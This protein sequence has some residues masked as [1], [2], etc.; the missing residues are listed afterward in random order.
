MA[1]PVTISNLAISNCGSSDFIES[2]D[3]GVDDG[4]EARQCA[5]WYDQA[6]KQALESHNWDFARKRLA[7]AEHSDD[8][9]AGQ[10]LYRYQYP[11]DCLKARQIENPLGPTADA[12]PFEIEISNEQKTILTDAEDAVLIYT[13]D[14][15][16][17]GLWSPMFI[18][19]F[20]YLL[21]HYIAFTITGNRTTKEKMMEAF[22]AWVRLATGSN[23]QEGQ[24]RAPRQADGIRAR[25]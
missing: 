6:R 7:L 16:S 8:P 14:T 18:S 22:G 4:K 20:S 1:D 5:L 17:V 11:A 3:P 12:I 19:A 13:Y 21:A 10:W 24:E 9:P 25:D 23:A 15:E 2:L